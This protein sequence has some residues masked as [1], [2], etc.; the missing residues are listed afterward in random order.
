MIVTVFVTN[1]LLAY[2]DGT[3]ANGVFY[4]FQRTVVI[5]ETQYT[6]SPIVR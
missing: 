2:Y 6:L 3:I 1:Y 5:N 4:P